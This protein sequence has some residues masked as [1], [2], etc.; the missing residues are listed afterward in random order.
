MNE[1]L[2]LR[3]FLSLNV[4]R[5]LELRS[6]LNWTASLIPTFF[7]KHRNNVTEANTKPV[8]VMNNGRGKEA[9]AQNASVID[10]MLNKGV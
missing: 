9:T 6:S 1:R 4:S 5:R 10:T 8:Q 7:Y 2:I 3:L